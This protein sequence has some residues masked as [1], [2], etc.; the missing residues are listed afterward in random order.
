MRVLNLTDLTTNYIKRTL[1]DLFEVMRASKLYGDY[2]ETEAYIDIIINNDNDI[3][4]LDKIRYEMT[5]KLHRSYVYDVTNALRKE[6]KEQ[7]V[8]IDS[9]EELLAFIWPVS[10]DGKDSWN[11]AARVLDT[12]IHVETSRSIGT[13]EHVPLDGSGAAL[14]NGWDCGDGQCDCRIEFLIDTDFPI[15]ILDPV[16][17]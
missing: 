17:V 2:M 11:S 16:T 10:K 1:T 14:D 12:P 4:M 3:D 15:Y 6:L 8:K 9:N 13:I 5:D 7:A